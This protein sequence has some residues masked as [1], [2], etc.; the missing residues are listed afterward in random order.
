MLLASVLVLE[1]VE[2]LGRGGGG[3]FVRRLVVLMRGVNPLRRKTKTKGKG[4][5]KPKGQ[6]R[7]RLKNARGAKKRN[8][9]RGKRKTQERRGNRIYGGYSI[10]TPPSVG[11]SSTAECFCL[12]DFDRQVL[13]A[14][15]CC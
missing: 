2:L 8:Q 4:E 12:V 5:G 10:L 7:R 15:I 9:T 13:A 6:G 11:G 14:E 1:E 3:R